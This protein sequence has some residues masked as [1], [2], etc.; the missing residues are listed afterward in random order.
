MGMA[1]MPGVVREGHVAVVNCAAHR[2]GYRSLAR[3]LDVLR[4]MDA[5]AVVMETAGMDC[6]DWEPAE[7]AIVGEAVLPLVAAWTG[8]PG[9]AGLAAGLFAD[10]RTGDASL[11]LDLGAIVNG[12]GARLRLLLAGRTAPPGPI[13][14][15]EAFDLGLVTGLGSEPGS[16]RREAMRIARAIAA[17][18]PLATQLAKEAIWRGLSLSLEQGLRTETDLTLLLQS[19]KDRAEGV[20]A[21]LEKREPEFG[22]E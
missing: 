15:V 8:D 9:P 16:A 1:D 12:A 17:N 2:G 14:G 19:T 21:F 5:R 22:G 13:G 11:A 3:T 7:A 10:V 6:G 20:R 18:G 4:D